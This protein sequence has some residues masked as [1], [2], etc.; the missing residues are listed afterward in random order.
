[1][2]PRQTFRLLL[3]PKTLTEKLPE[4]NYAPGCISQP[5]FWDLSDTLPSKH[6]A[7][8][9]TGRNK[10]N[11]RQTHSKHKA[12]P[13]KTADSQHVRSLLEVVA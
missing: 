11:C 13:L 10:T 2:Q 6:P 1:M 4:N 7:P 12:P 3:M 8:E 9:K 5:L